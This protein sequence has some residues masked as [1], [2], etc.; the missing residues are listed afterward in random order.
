[1]GVSVAGAELL[2]ASS[3]SELPADMLPA[4]LRFAKRLQSAKDTGGED[5]TFVQR[6][7]IQRFS[8]LY[9]NFL[10]SGFYSK[11]LRVPV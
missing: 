11:L 8:A 4:W 7:L 1:M 6:R 2:L 9:S 5:A 3:R 10:Y